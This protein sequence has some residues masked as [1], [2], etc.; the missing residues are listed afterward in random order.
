MVLE[1]GCDAGS[2]VI[3]KFE[4]VA[5]LPGVYL[6]GAAAI[7]AISSVTGFRIAIEGEVRVTHRALV[8]FHVNSPLPEI[9]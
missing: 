2:I 9:R 6:D 1:V 3:N 5:S 7:G 4:L 8:I